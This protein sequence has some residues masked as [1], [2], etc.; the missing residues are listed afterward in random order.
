M[1]FSLQGSLLQSLKNE[2]M[3]SSH[4]RVNTS[5]QGRRTRLRSLHGLLRRW[6]QGNSLFIL[7]SSLNIDPSSYPVHYL[8]QKIQKQKSRKMDL[9]LGGTCKLDPVGYMWHPKALS[10]PLLLDPA[11]LSFPYLGLGNTCLFTRQ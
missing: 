2:Q 1:E 8:L 7:H 3:R 9:F 4:I 5:D 11:N 6:I 10:D